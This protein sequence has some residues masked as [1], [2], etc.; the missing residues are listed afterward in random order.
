MSGIRPSAWLAL[1]AL[2]LGV[3]V[4]ALA[5]SPLTEKQLHFLE[6]AGRGRMAGRWTELDTNQLAA[7]RKT[8]DAYAADIPRRHQVGGLIVSTRHADTNRTA[9]LR[10]E[11]LQDSSAWTGFYL[12]GLAYWFAVDRRADTL[13]QV[14]VTL[15][16]VERLLQTTPRPGYIPAFVGRADDPAYREVYSRHGGPDP[17]RPGFGRL[18]FQGDAANRDLVWLGGA[19]RDNY[20]GLIL[21]LAMVHKFIREPRIRARVSN[22]VELVIRRL[23]ADK[24]RI[25]DGH[26]NETFVTPLL[27]A[28]ILRLGAS[29]N[30]NRHLRAFEAR[31]DEVVDLP[32]PVAPRYAD[33]RTAVF[34]AANL[35]TLGG[36]ETSKKRAL[37]F[38]DKV[39]RLWRDSGNPLNPW[40]AVVFVNAFDH[41]PSETIAIATLQGVLALY[42]PSPR[43]RGPGNLASTN[44]L[45]LVAANG[46]YWSKAALPLPEQGV[47]AFQWV[48][49]GTSLQPVP[50]EPVAHPGVDLFTT[51]WMARDSGVLRDEA[52]PI[53][54]VGPGLR[55]TTDFR[56]RT[57]VTLAIPAPKPVADTNINRPRL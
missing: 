45:E 35:A 21:G 13:E 17:E 57:N 24:W 10:Y 34:A 49:A 37:G 4:P 48:R 36:L 42:P 2:L 43:W 41:A 46:R 27:G 18:A 44:G 56:A 51:Y 33:P 40:L 25:Q 14:R 15:D 53:A 12:A 50:A 19:S 7:L 30:T 28:A 22:D 32:P 54:S 8:V 55:R 5:Q 20:S 39:T 38:Q 6:N 16:G 26:G 23:E 9:V 11:E 31:A 47:E 1:A 29:V 3:A 52:A